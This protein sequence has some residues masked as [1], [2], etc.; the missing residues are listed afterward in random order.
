MSVSSKIIFNIPVDYCSAS[1]LLIH[2]NSS[3]GDGPTHVICTWPAI[4]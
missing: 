2:F 3:C 4:A 1:L